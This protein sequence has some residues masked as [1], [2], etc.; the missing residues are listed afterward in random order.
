[1]SLWHVL[2]WLQVRGGRPPYLQLVNVH[3]RTARV[4]SPSLYEA[5]CTCWRAR[6]HWRMC[7]CCVLEV[8]IRH[9]SLRD[10]ACV[11]WCPV[12]WWD[13]RVSSYAAGNGC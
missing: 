10:C 6:F 13:V 5:A 4:M 3:I 9:R 2:C 11:C 7:A 8:L 1:M 12:S